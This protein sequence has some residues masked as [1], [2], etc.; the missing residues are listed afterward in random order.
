MAPG[1]IIVDIVF[2]PIY[3]LLTIGSV[4]NALK[5][6]KTGGFIQLCIFALLRLVG[7]I[8]LVYA[9]YSKTTN[10]SVYT[11]GALFTGLGYSFLVVSVGASQCFRGELLNL[12]ALPHRPPSSHNSNE[13]PSRRPAA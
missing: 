5:H 12:L 8:L 4:F 1:N 3:A 13:Q 9:Y 11:V 7:T 10:T 6:R 2:I